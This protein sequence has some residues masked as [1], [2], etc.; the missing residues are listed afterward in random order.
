MHTKQR[1]G[2]LGTFVILIAL[3]VGGYYGYK[4]FVSPSEPQ[5]CA[6]QLQSCMANC[7]KTSTEAPEAKA[8]QDACQRGAAACKEP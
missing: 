3:G 1:G 7:R 2:A 4:M 8:C 5:S 6:A